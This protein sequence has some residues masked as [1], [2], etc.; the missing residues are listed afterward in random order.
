MGGPKNN[1]PAQHAQ[2]QN[3]QVQHCSEC[4][5]KENEICTNFISDIL[6]PSKCRRCGHKKASHINKICNNFIA[7]NLDNSK[8]STCGHTEESHIKHNINTLG[9]SLKVPRKLATPATPA[10]SAGTLIGGRLPY[11]SRTKKRT[12]RRHKK[13]TRRRHKKN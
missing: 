13:Q 12:Q 7:D 10:T 6:N 1:A 5:G 9:S 3:A 11:K 8:C 4:D 2:A